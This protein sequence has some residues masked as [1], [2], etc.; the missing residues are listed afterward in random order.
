ME[1][2]FH[3]QNDK[4]TASSLHTLDFKGGYNYIHLSCSFSNRQ[5][6]LKQDAQEPVEPSSLKI[7]RFVFNNNMGNL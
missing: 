2:A 7:L 1:H 6:V 3:I 4:F 5:T